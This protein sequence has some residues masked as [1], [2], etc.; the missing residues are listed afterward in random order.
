[1]GICPVTN[2]VSVFLSF[3]FFPITNINLNKLYALKNMF[4]YTVSVKLVR[5][6]NII[7]CLD[8]Y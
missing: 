1:M 6:I 8:K 5:K 7:L 3:P 2:V 4:K